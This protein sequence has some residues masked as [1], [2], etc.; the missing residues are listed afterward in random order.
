MATY[1][2]IFDLRSNNALRNKI[3]VAVVVKAQ[4][5]IDL[6]SPTAGQLSWANNAMNNPIASADKI[7]HYV[8]A[9]NKSSTTSQISSASDSAI[10][11]NVDAAADKLIAGGIVG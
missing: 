8:L 7:M 5:L 2:E 4:T 11:T 10:Q 3:A 9:A 6:A 1:A